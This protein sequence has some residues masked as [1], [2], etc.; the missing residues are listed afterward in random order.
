MAPQLITRTTKSTA[1]LGL[2]SG[3]SMYIY[4]SHTDT[5][6]IEKPFEQLHGLPSFST[7]FSAQRPGLRNPQEPQP[8]PQKPPSCR[9]PR[10][11]PRSS[12]RRPPAGPG[13]APSAA[14]AAAPSKCGRPWD[15][16]QRR[17]PRCPQDCFFEKKLTF[18]LGSFKIREN[19]RL[20]I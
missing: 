6:Q 1:N 2:P 8:V 12:R 20:P 13:G 5:G 9:R 10:G 16:T 3:K 19:Q 4:K 17:C 15:A 7:I 18:I 14:A 11:P